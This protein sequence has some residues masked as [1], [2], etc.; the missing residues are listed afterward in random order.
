MAEVL[1]SFAQEGFASVLLVLGGLFALVG[2]ARV[3][4]AF[5]QGDPAVPGGVLMVA[6]GLGVLATILPP[7]NVWMT[8]P[9]R[10]WMGAHIDTP[11]EEIWG[12]LRVVGLLVCAHGFVAFIL[13]IA[14]VGIYWL[15]V[16]STNVL[17]RAVQGLWQ[18]Y[19]GK[20]EEEEEEAPALVA[21]PQPSTG[22]FAPIGRA[23]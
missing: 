21:L 18:R 3:F 10:T 14:A 23:S 19:F 13:A 7:L 12:A 11:S 5:K 22:L 17:T 15:T 9:V 2:L 1:D 8:G 4:T 16:W 6:L 20:P